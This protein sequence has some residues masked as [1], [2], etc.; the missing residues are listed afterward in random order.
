MNDYFIFVESLML[1]EKSKN[2]Q[3]DKNVFVEQ[4]YNKYLSNERYPFNKFQEQIENLFYEPEEEINISDNFLL[5]DT[6]FSKIEKIFRNTFYKKYEKDEEK[7]KIYSTILEN[8]LSEK[9]TQN[10]HNFIYNNIFKD[11]LDKEEK[12]FLSNK[13]NLDLKKLD[14]KKLELEQNQLSN[15]NYEEI[16]KFE[17]FEEILIKIK[18]LRKN[19]KVLKKK[20]MNT[21]MKKKIYIQ[22]EIDNISKE[23]NLYITNEDYKNYIKFKKINKDISE[24]SKIVE[25]NTLFFEQFQFKFNHMKKNNKDKTL[26]KFI[27]STDN[28]EKADNI[29]YFDIYKFYNKPDIFYDERVI[30]KTK[31]EFKGNNF[32]IHYLIDHDAIS[33]SNIGSEDHKLNYELYILFLYYY[34]ISNKNIKN[35]DKIFNNEIKNKIFSNEIKNKI[36]KFENL[37]NKDYIFIVLYIYHYINIVHSKKSISI[38]MTLTSQEKKKIILNT[39]KTLFNLLTNEQMKLIVDDHSAIKL[40]FYQFSNIIY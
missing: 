10:M 12:L 33:E 6:F 18:E 11:Y 25:L 26:G 39:E 24:Y 32:L 4:F 28:S 3:L 1:K 34:K 2:P 13:S 35:I 36:L 5:Y 14:L 19:V 29:K 8:I 38:P 30:I 22:N 21:D 20:K 16:K 40:K 27:P 23:L 37:Q 15:S 7:K 31:K 17:E 9:E